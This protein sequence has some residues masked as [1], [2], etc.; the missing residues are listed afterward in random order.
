MENKITSYSN[1][2]PQTKLWKGNVFTSVCQEFC[3]W[4]GIPPGRHPPWQT[5]PWADAP[6]QMATAA[7][8]THPT[9][10]H[11]PLMIKFSSYLYRGFASQRSI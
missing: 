6:Q 11:Y 9:G 10:I 8:R 5:P 2:H 4:G 1:Y 3:A 7:D